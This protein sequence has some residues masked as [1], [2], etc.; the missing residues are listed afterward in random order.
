[1]PLDAPQQRPLWHPHHFL[2]LQFLRPGALHFGRERLQTP[3]GNESWLLGLTRKSHLVV[4]PSR[5]CDIVNIMLG[6]QCADF[7]VSIIQILLDPLPDLL[8]DAQL[9]V[10]S[11]EGIFERQ[12]Y[13]S[14]IWRVLRRRI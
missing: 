6:Y 8:C 10:W 4:V 9:C 5:Y 2:L 13:Q 11:L 1:M 14:L 3:Q 12:V 7:C